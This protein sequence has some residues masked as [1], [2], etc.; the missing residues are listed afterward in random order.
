MALVSGEGVINGLIAGLGMCGLMALS[1][2]YYLVV[3]RRGS[4]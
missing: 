2:I 1:G 4:Q 3:Y